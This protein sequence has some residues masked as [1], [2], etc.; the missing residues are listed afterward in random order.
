MHRKSEKSKIVGKN[1][2]RRL[3][4]G[5]LFGVIDPPSSSKTAWDEIFNIIPLKYL[6]ELI[7]ESGRGSGLRKPFKTLRTNG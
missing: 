5:I 4:A 3:F 2:D 1:L 6:G 7:Y